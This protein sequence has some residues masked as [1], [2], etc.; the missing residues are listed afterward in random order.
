MQCRNLSD[1]ALELEIKNSI[2]EET[3]INM[4]VLQLLAESEGYVLE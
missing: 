2:L 1:E 4:K 3:K